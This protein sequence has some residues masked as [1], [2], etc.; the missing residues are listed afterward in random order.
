MFFRWTLTNS[1]FI[2]ILAQIFFIPVKN[3]WLFIKIRFCHHIEN[4]SVHIFLTFTA[5]ISVF[6]LTIMVVFLKQAFTYLP[7]YRQNRQNGSMFLHQLAQSKN[8]LP[9]GRRPCLKKTGYISAFSRYFFQIG[10]SAIIYLPSPKLYRSN[11]QQK[12]VSVLRS[13]QCSCFR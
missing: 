6:F 12:P 1:Y 2:H 13:E 9:F 4:S 10:S 7:A 8:R 5:R 11:G 3:K